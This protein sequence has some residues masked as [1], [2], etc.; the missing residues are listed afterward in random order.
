MFFLGAPALTSRGFS[1]ADFVST[2]QLLDRGINIGKAVVD[3]TGMCVLCIWFSSV[4]NALRYERSSRREDVFATSYCT[5]CNTSGYYFFEVL[6]CKC[7]II[8]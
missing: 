7:D 6:Q 5:R 3:E 8:I 2:M 1:E 4:E